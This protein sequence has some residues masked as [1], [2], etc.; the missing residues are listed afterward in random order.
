MSGGISVSDRDFGEDPVLW[1]PGGRLA[2]HDLHHSYAGWNPA[3]VYG[4]PGH[5]SFQDLSGN[6]EKTYLYLWR[7]E[8]ER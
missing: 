3:S 8:P 5:V 2:F 7:D 6:K 1:G 4:N